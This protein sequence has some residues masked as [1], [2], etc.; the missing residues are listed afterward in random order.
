MAIAK[1][2]DRAH[3]RT[4]SFDFKGTAFSGLTFMKS[5]PGGR[6]NLSW[7]CAS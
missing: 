1:G 7:D 4:E 3:K 6:A 5:T 2:R